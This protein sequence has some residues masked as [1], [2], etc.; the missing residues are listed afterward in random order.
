MN[1]LWMHRRKGR[2]DKDGAGVKEYTVDAQ[3]EG[4]EGEGWCR[5]E[6]IYC[7]CSGGKGRRDEDGAGVNEYTVDAQEGREGGTRMVQE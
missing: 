1:I 4:K 7:G 5:S 3:E 6:W 2:R